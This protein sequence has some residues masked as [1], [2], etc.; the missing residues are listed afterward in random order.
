MPV[1]ELA[2]S[3][4]Y[5]RVLDGRPSTF[6]PGKRFT[7]NTS[8]FVLLAV[9]AE[10]AA[11]TDLPAPVSDLV[12]DPAGMPDTAFFLRTDSCPARRRGLP[13]ATGLRT[14]VLHLPV[15]GS[16]D[17]GTCSTLADLHAL[18]SAPRRQIVAPSLVGA[19]AP[20]Q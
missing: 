9:L 11:G 14:N 5:L 12:C 17:G 7:Y 15:R 8:G 10:R 20:A 3:E 2:T 18:W 6:A 13:D 1:H 4:A 16:G 19:G